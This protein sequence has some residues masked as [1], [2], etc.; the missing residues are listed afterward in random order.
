MLRLLVAASALNAS[1]LST[2]DDF[3]PIQNSEKSTS[4]PLSPAETASQ[5][6]LPAGFHLS[7]IASEPHVQNPIAM[8]TDERGRIWI[9]ENY[10][11]SGNGAGG[12]DPKQRDRIVVL[13]DSD[14]DGTYENR[15]VFADNVHKLTSIEIGN[16]G[17]YAISLPNLLFFPDLNRDDVPDSQ[18]Q[19][20]LNGFDDDAVGHTPAN[21]LKWGSDGWL[22]GRHG[23]QAT[24]SIGTPE[25]TDSQRIKINT[26]VWRFHPTSKRV[27]TVMHGMTNSWGFD[28]DEHG[29]MFVIN[30]VIGHLWHVVPGAHVERM[31][32]ID[33]NP[34]AFQLIEQTADHVHWD[35]GEKWNEIQKGMSNLTD[36]A[37]GGHAHIGLM[38]YQ[39][40]NWPAEYRNKLF[41]LNLH[42]LRINSN[43]LERQGTAYV[44]RRAPDFAFLSDPWFRGMELITAPDGSV[45]IADWSDTG[46]CHDHDGVHRTSG[47]VYRLAY[48]SPKTIKPFDLA[49]E[50]IE[51]LIELLS[52]PNAWWNRTAR[53]LL[54]E[55]LLSSDKSTQ[56]SVSS[57]LQE[58]IVSCNEV[59]RLLRYLEVMFASNLATED[60]LR[61][62]LQHDNEHVR[63]NA[64]RFLID[65]STV[66][67][68]NLSPES[69]QVFEK[70][71]IE[72]SSGLVHLYLASALQRLPYEQRWGIAKG[73][74]Q[75]SQWATDRTFPKM[76]WYGVEGAVPSDVDRAIQLI[77]SS[78][79]PLLTENA[80]RRLTLLLE[81]KPTAVD[82]LVALACRDDFAFAGDIVRGMAK[83]LEG[84]QKAA[85][86]KGWEKLATRIEHD[87]ASQLT[88]ELQALRLTF[89]DGRAKEDLLAM[90]QNGGLDAAARKQALR[91]L[92]MSKP[93]DLA[94]KL[95]QW[96]GDRA[97]AMEA[98]R[99]LAQ[100]DHPGVAQQLLS[101][102]K[103]YSPAERAE[104][105]NTLSARPSTAKAMLEAIRNGKIAP[106]DVSAFHARQIQSFGDGDLTALLSEVWGE[107]KS[108][109][110]ERKAWMDAWR[111][112]MDIEFVEKADLGNGRALFQQHCSNC[113]VMYGVGKRIGPDLTGSNR[114]N[115]DYLL[116][117][118]G[119]PSASVGAE[120]RTTIIRLDDERVITGVVVEKTDRTVTVQTAQERITLDNQSIEATKQSTTSLMPDGLLQNLSELQIRDLLAY[121]MHE[122]QVPLSE[123]R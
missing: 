35:T 89:G 69:L 61:S 117:N 47:R 66:S 88:K 46:E 118:I 28:F 94:P 62:L 105:I 99:G 27:E 31:Y 102:W 86:P 36:A 7:V 15:K 82:S 56:A 91:S 108:S 72:D 41:T 78:R 48:G 81:T 12:F 14:G 19:I 73:L 120:F 119:D 8:T 74:S 63:V 50:S 101:R 70:L 4:L 104:V 59:P 95:L 123:Q 22:Y 37:G 93:N 115:L 30:T 32:G 80:A 92:V 57:K 84:W 58:K 55:R 85:P 29:Q 68:P 122:S 60:F 53:R 113:H 17:V 42:G 64:I 34:F 39:G 21:G 45:L 24:S 75:Q 38:I 25:A 97:L 9:A 71:A 77:A 18:A 43:S 90:V 16:G 111:Q 6:R 96:L 20:L 44:G 13:E 83:A 87:H 33:L 2:A 112:K 54:T 114:R 103:G 98:I 107:I 110:A 40:D 49:K 79:I 26:G 1:Q 116:E 106:S 5:A 121:L 10:S 51:S 11:W 109:S 52:H 100:Y 23:I 65:A 3:P 67:E 76:L